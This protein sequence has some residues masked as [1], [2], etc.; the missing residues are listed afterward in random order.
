M[1]TKIIAVSGRKFS[2]KSSLCN[3]L[4]AHVHHQTR[5][6]PNPKDQWAIDQDSSGVIRWFRQQADGYCEISPPQAEALN[7]ESRIYNFADALKQT[8]IDVLGLSYEQVWGTEEQKN[9][10]TKFSWDNLPAFVRWINS[11][12]HEMREYLCG[13]WTSHHEINTEKG[14]ISHMQMGFVPFFEKRGFMTAREV[15][16]VMGTEIMRKM[17]HDSVWVDAT[18][19]KISKDGPKIAF[20]ADCRFRSEFKAVHDAGG[21]IIRLERS[22]FKDAHA[23][24]IDMD[25]FDFGKYDRTLVVP[26]VDIQTKNKMVVEWFDRIVIKE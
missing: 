6:G 26:D 2:G 5:M 10:L 14:F 19:R 20:I 3:Y 9:S 22:I 8:C 23:S 13:E 18:L 21:Y 4:Q 15:M 1:D 17:F 16:Q 25:G 24:E 11:S 12:K 7:G